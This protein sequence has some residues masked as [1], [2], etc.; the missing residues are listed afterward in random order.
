MLTLLL[1][2]ASCIRQSVHVL[3]G[4]RAHGYPLQ[5][6]LLHLKDM[7]TWAA[8]VK[9]SY[10]VL[11]WNAT[12]G[13]RLWK[14]KKNG[15][16]KWLSCRYRHFS[17]SSWPERILQHDTDWSNDKLWEFHCSGVPVIYFAP[18]MPPFTPDVQLAA[19][20][21]WQ[22]TTACGSLSWAISATRSHDSFEKD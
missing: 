10:L 9:A 11:L 6:H 18:V 21:P 15:V 12:P 8:A 5:L 14:L 3:I 13:N 2:Q 7:S 4:C 19:T 22:T 17:V 1:F 16:Q 20:G